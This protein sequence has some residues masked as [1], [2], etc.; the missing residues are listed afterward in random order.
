MYLAKVQ[1]TELKWYLVLRRPN[2]ELVNIQSFH[3]SHYHCVETWALGIKES[4]L[5]TVYLE[6]N[7]L[8]DSLGFL[9]LAFSHFISLLKL[10]VK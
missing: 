2:C 3:L 8:P 5:S 7:S 9:I 1:C 10:Q 4:I 6:I